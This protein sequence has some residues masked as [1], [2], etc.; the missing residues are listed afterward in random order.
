MTI[1]HIVISGGGPSG[2]YAYGAAKYLEQQHF[3]SIDNIQTIYA[4]SIGAFI[5]VL[6]CLKYDWD[7][8]DDYLI[9]RPWD[10]IFSVSPNDLLR[11][12]DEKGILGIECAREAIRPLLEAKDLSVDITLD[13]FFW[14]TNIELHVF[15]VNLNN[16]LLCETDIS[17]KTHPNMP[18]VKAL[19]ITTA[20]PFVFKPIIDGDKCYIDGGLIMNFPVEPCLK[21]TCCDPNEILAFQNIWSIESKINK[22]NET[23]SILNYWTSIISAVIKKLNTKGVDSVNVTVPNTVNC[24]I[25]NGGYEAW[26]T[27]IDH[28]DTREAFVKKGEAL[29][30]MFYKYKMSN[31]VGV[32]DVK[33]DI[34]T[35]EDV[36]A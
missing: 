7:V 36:N 23:T 27:A 31:N 19:A 21:S 12:W 33:E 10:K 18:L 16:E 26:S 2:F 11:V 34:N 4:T 14:F 24:L 30:F 15:A 3:W 13:E 6:L 17:Y 1:K 25:D 8:T 32:S 22:V 5:G 9:K 20:F 28:T 35:K 29:G